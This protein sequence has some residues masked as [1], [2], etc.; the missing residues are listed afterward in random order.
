L[1]T[2]FQHMLGTPAY[3]SPEQ[4]ALSGLDID[5]RADIYSLGVLLYELLTGVTP[6]DADALRKAAMDEIRRTICER[7]PQ[8]P[9]TRLHTLGDKLAAVAKHRG[10]VPAALNRIIRGDLDWIV[11][12]CLEKDRKR[13]YETASDLAAD[14][15][16]HLKSEAVVARPPSNLYRF[17]KL[18]RRHK[19][20]F[21]AAG[22]VAAALVI[23]L[24]V[25]TWSLFREKEARQVAVA[26]QK[27]QVRLRQKAEIEAN[28]SRQVA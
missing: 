24:G 14:V 19:F 7:E 15:A 10:T 9:S 27:E 25:S 13:R 22:A 5:T 3:M 6:F 8:K 21:A 17:Q 12:R 2:G 16:R 11:M 1:F 18:V 26:A 28:K 23:G 20:A 4:A